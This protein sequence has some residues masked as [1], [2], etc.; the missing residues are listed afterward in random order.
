MSRSASS[1][2]NFGSGQP[3]A[4]HPGMQ[5]LM[6]NQQAQQQPQVMPQQGMPRPM[7]NHVGIFGASSGQPMPPQGIAQR[8]QQMRQ[9]MQAQ[10]QQMR[11]QQMQNPMMR[12][13]Q[14]ASM[15]RGLRGPM[16]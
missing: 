1:P 4:K 16:Q 8:G 3:T 12:Q 2:G 15:L 7:P 10:G 11:G 13:A 9:M 5:L 6:Q 14:M